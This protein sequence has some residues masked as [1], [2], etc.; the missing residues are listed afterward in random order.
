MEVGFFCSQ[1]LGKV[2]PVSFG[3]NVGFPEKVGDATGRKC[4][5]FQAADT[6][7]RGISGWKKETFHLRRF[8]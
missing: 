2:T 7:K 8:F 5:N 6:V 3:E 1:P 4:S